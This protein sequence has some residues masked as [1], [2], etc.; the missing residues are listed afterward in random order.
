MYSMNGTN[1]KLYV[2]ANPLQTIATTGAGISSTGIVIGA[3][4]TARQ[5]KGNIDEV[6][7]YNRNLNDTE[8]LNN[9]L[10]GRQQLDQQ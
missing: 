9:Y 8:I 10:I 7:I 2:N 5:F 1:N 4:S 3:E 6:L